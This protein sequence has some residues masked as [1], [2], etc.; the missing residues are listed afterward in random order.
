MTVVLLVRHAVTNE[1]GKRLYGRAAGVHLSDE[2]VEQAKRVASRLAEVPLAALYSSP[3]E[4]CVETAAPIAEACRLAVRVLPDATEIDYG[5]LTGRTFAAL[6][7]TRLWRRLHA[8][9]STV[10]FPDGESLAT[11][12]ERVVES[13]RSVA[14]R[15]PRSLVAVVSHGDPIRLALAHYG[16]I[17]VDLYHRIEAAP[18]SISAVSVGG[19]P[20]ILRLND[21]GALADLVP[22]RPRRSRG[23]SG[24]RR[25]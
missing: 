1:T 22:A 5:E 17:H 20:R 13:L 7:R 2:G 15:H 25:R 12:Q 10:R 23:P 9:P 14:D 6:A 21:T 18:A 24:R 19:V 11:A 16:G 3:L 4:R 8:A